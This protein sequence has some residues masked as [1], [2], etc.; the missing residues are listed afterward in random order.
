TS[1]SGDNE[2][3]SWAPNGRYI[4][5]ASTRNGP[6]QI[7]IMRDDGS[8]QIRIGPKMESRQPDWSPWFK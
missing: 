5:F 6:S 4:T 3:P 1:N 7:F 2:S 8:N